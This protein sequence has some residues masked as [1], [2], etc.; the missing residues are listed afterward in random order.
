MN[1][2][3]TSSLVALIVLV[4]AGLSNAADVQVIRVPDGG[5]QPQ[6]Q[7]DSRGRV[8]MIYFTGDPSRGDV[9]YVR[10]D[11]GGSSFTSPLRVNSQSQSVIAIGT[12]R[13]P[14]LALGK[15]DR[16][17][18]SWMGSDR[19]QPKVGGKD[20]PLLYA[21][22]NDAGDG[23]EP[24]RNVIVNHPGLDGGQAVAADAQGNVYVAWHAPA[25]E[26]NEADRHVWIARSHDEGKTFEPETMA[27]NDPTGVCGCCG[28]N[29]AAG[30]NGQVF[31]LY[32]SATEMVHRDMYLLAS[33]DHAATFHVVSKDPWTI[34][35]CAMSTAAFFA[36]K[37][38][39]LAAWETQNQIHFARVDAVR[40]DAAHQSEPMI[41][42][43]AGNPGNRKH[44]AITAN[45]DGE[46]IIAW[47]EGTGWNKGGAVAWQILDKD[48]KPQL[49]KPG[50]I[51][52]LAAWDKPAV[53][54]AP[55]GS[56]RVIF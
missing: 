23:F 4:L 1:Y 21:R 41:Q 24:Q 19:A 17:H 2:L 37:D 13:G 32:R 25:V 9:Y 40:D 22:M 45:A 34:G 20:V 15:N 38:K 49:R 56:F 8:H 54:V 30:P 55:D 53:F 33:D 44:P 50:H 35:T 10:S 28:M 47:A 43:I 18:V 48:G 42:S 52:G 46:F 26:R 11:D 31:I 14:H 3:S 16:V 29:I 6:V 36:S 7:T 27:L 12:V 5:I 39:M 51:D